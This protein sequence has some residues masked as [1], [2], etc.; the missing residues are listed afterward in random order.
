M[1]ERELDSS[2]QEAELVTGVVART[3]K[4]NRV[5]RTPPQERTHGVSNLNLADRAG[6]CLLK[7][8]EDVRRQHVTTDDCQIRRRFRKRRFFNHV[9]DLINTVCHFLAIDYAE[10]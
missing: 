5:K 7:L 3:F 9:P 1:L 10:P 4:A 8:V 2:N 6:R